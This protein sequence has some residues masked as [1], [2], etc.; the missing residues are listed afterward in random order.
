MGDTGQDTGQDD[1]NWIDPTVATTYEETGINA[2]AIGRETGLSQG[3]WTAVDTAI[4][5][6]PGVGEAWMA[7]NFIADALRSGSRGNNAMSPADEARY[8][9]GMRAAWDRQNK[10]QE[11]KRKLREKI[12]NGVDPE[13]FSA[14]MALAPQREIEYNRLIQSYANKHSTDANY[15]KSEILR[16]ST[17][18]HLT[19]AQVLQQQIRQQELLTNRA[20]TAPLVNQIQVR[21]GARNRL[22][23]ISKDQQIADQQTRANQADIERNRVVQTQLAGIQTT[24]LQNDLLNS[25][26]ELQHATANSQKLTRNQQ[27]VLAATIAQQ[28]ARTTPGL[29]GNGSILLNRVMSEFDMSKSEAKRY[30]KKYGDS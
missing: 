19:P 14:L 22:L 1:P 15:L 23:D 5:L 25:S 29:V 11:A 24:N 3:A 7:V 9:E 18:R 4:S 26:L 6:I 28:R 2:S 12:L 8:R 27:R 13:T 30:I 21:Q 17:K 20:P 16:P 10:R